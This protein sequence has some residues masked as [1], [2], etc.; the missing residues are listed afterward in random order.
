M[1]KTQ[2]T[3]SVNASS[4]QKRFNDSITLS[5]ELRFP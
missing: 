5:E 1:R 4:F 2:K 3:L